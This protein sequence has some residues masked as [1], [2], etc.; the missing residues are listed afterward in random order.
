MI[1]Y[2]VKRDA[3]I[4]TEMVKLGI[5]VRGFA[6]HTLRD[7]EEYVSASKGAPPISSYASF[8]KLFSKLGTPRR[9]VE[10]LT[11]AHFASSSGDGLY[12]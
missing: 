4:S 10:D 3:A 5:Q 6:S 2:A 1:R 9:P 7:M 11:A 12:F 8:Y